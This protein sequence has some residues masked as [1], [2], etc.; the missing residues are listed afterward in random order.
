MSTKGFG[1]PGGAF[2]AEGLILLG[3]IKDQNRALLN[4]KGDILLPGRSTTDQICTLQPIFERSWEYAKD[5]YACFAD[6]RK[7]YDQV[8]RE[9]LQAILWDHDLK[10]RLLMGVKAL[11]SCS[12]VGVC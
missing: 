4:S 3:S 6:L 1:K 11:P 8:P 7:A 10:R 9:K 12:E 5:T 2:V